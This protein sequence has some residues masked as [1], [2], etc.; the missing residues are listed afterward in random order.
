MC[1]VF[2]TIDFNALTLLSKNVDLIGFVYFGYT[3]KPLRRVCVPT[4]IRAWQTRF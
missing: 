3:V 4:R 2:R 1:V